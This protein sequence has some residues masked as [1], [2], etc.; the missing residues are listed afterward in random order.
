MKQEYKHLN[1]F[2]VLIV[3]IMAIVIE[4]T[5]SFTYPFIVIPAFCITI[6]TM[7]GIISNLNKTK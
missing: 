3:G 6:A 1:T 4:L 7:V 2:I 5:F